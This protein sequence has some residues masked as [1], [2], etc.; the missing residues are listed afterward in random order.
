MADLA[1]QKAALIQNISAAIDV[2]IRDSIELHYAQ[3]RTSESEV[4]DELR[5]RVRDAKELLHR[6]LEQLLL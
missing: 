2:M 5:D 1:K 6:S 4:L 3:T